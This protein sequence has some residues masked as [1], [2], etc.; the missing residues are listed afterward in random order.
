MHVWVFS[1]CSGICLTASRGSP[2]LCE[3]LLVWWP[4]LQHPSFI[5][6]H[7]S[8]ACTQYQHLYMLDAAVSSVASKN[9]ISRLHNTVSCLMPRAKAKSS[10][11]GMFCLFCRDMPS[12][13]SVLA[14]MVPV[15]S[16]TVMQICLTFLTP[17]F[18]QMLQAQ[19]G[20][21]CPFHEQR[22]LGRYVPSHVKVAGCHHHECY[23]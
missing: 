14:G 19:S 2:Y 10:L 7:T 18:M 16:I 5:Q 23:E 22:T 12:A 13:V 21:I 20:V 9:V 4:W 8:S 17:Y 11:S 6:K 15:S 1:L 3:R